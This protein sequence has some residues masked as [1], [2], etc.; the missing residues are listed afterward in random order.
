[1]ASITFTD[2]GGAVTLTNGLTGPGNRF[3][4]WTPTIFRVT[5]RRTALGTGVHYEFVYR[6]DYVAAFS[7]TQM[8]ATQL[9]AVAR[10]TKW[11]EAGNTFTVNTTDNSSRTYTCRLADGATVNVSMTDPVF[12]EYTV[13]VTV[14]SA[15]SPK[16]FLTCE[17]L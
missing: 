15:S 8:P 2:G 11:A 14:S 12:C 3:A 4:N 13:E 9:E 7:M 1:M 16:V 6:E 10:F 17:Y 5:D